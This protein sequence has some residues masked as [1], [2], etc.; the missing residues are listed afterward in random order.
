MS[1]T[2]AT[3]LNPGTGLLDRWA[4]S[5]MATYAP[6]PIALVRGAGSLVWDDQG[7]EYVDL[8]GGIAVNLLGHAHPA[9][10]DAVGRQIATL[11]HVSNLVANAPAAELAERL[12]DLT[13]REG[14]VFFCNSGAEANEAAF[15]L[16]R[17]TGRASV[18]AAEGS[19]HGRTMGALALTGQPAKRAPFEPL[20][21]GVTFVPYGDGPALQ[22]AVGSWTA[23]AILEPILGEGGVVPAPDGYLATARAATA[24]QGALLVIDEVQTGLGRTG[25]WFVST[26]VRPDVM[27]LAK[28]LGGGLPIGA[29]LAFDDAAQLL[30][31][32]QHGST[33]GGNP[34]S[35]AAALAVLDTIEKE[36]LCERADALG[37]RLKHGIAGVG[38]PLVDEVRGAG[39]M[40]GITLRA[41]V[42]AAVET[43]ARDRGFLVNTVA[44]DV[45]RLLPPLV[46]TDAQVDTFLTVLPDAL[47]AASVPAGAGADMTDLREQT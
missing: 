47:D 17:R 45:V 43:A 10:V 44:P 32:G 20:P 34:V 38:H 27:T 39:L 41:P 31:P 22:S 24:Q 19:F 1:P 4:R 42:A 3:E 36:G 5:V 21:G 6:P 28:G 15:K 40:L 30:A 7:R 12:L 35:C 46:L 23:A 18:V 29:C 11:G 16:A 13:G 25:S 26:G 2:A 9:V 33:F 14:R 37:K 8:V